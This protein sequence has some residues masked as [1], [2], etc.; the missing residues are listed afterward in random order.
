M[1]A[2]R[3]IEANTLICYTESGFNNCHRHFPDML[4]AVKRGVLAQGGVGR[5]VWSMTRADP[6]A[7]EFFKSL[8]TLS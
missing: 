5:F 1:V 4:E 6:Q 2:A 7:V 8:V 3:E